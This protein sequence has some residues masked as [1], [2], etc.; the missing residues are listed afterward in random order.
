MPVDRYPY[1]MPHPSLGDL[2][3]WL[4]FNQL[5]DLTG[6]IKP[7]TV[8]LT[9]VEII[10]TI[11]TA[12]CNMG[13]SL[14]TGMVTCQRDATPVENAWCRVN[15]MQHLLTGLRISKSHASS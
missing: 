14:S 6:L 3:G 10:K 5:L 8:L 13:Q 1:A 4:T 12:F 7:T 11:L 9:R 2:L 15:R